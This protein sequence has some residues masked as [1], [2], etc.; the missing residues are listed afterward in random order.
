VIPLGPPGSEAIGSQIGS[1]LAAVSVKLD[2][3]AAE[4][5]QGA[6]DSAALMLLSGMN[7]SAA[8]KTA[9]Y[10]P[11]VVT[12]SW[13]QAGGGATVAQESTAAGALDRG[14]LLRLRWEHA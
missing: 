9:W 13:L 4:W 12:A 10:A 7:L 1:P 6:D 14:Q 8:P 2:P 11:E 5:Q 3:L